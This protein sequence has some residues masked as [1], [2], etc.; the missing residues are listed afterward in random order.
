MVFDNLLYVTLGQI[1]L[2]VGVISLIIINLSSY[3]TYKKELKSATELKIKTAVE[4]QIKDVNEKQ[5]VVIEKLN[6]LEMLLN[7]KVEKE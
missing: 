3:I 1:V 7:N 4:E 6:K 2:G 5:E